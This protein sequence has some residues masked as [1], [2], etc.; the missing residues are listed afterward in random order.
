PMPRRRGHRRRGTPRA[1]ARDRRKGDVTM[2]KRIETVTRIYELANERRV[3][4]IEELVTYPRLRKRL[5]W[6]FERVLAVEPDLRFVVTDPREVGSSVTFQL[7]PTGT[8]LPHEPA[9]QTVRFK[10]NDPLDLRNVY[11]VPDSPNATAFG[12]HAVRA[13]LLSA[14]FD[15]ITDI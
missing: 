8:R 12:G 5:V 6:F 7:R 3:R 4:E 15:K 11:T 9:T 2:S 13:P 10:G 1:V 14:V